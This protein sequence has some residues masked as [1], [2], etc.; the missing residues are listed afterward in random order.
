MAAYDAYFR[1]TLHAYLK[2]EI[3][4]WRFVYLIDDLVF[5]NDINETDRNIWQHADELV[6]LS[7]LVTVEEFRKNEKAFKDRIR[8][9]YFQEINHNI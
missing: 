9:V 4:L 8:R 5:S 6:G 1:E 2:D 3:T 7:E